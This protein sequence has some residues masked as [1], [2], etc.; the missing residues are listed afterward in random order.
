MSQSPTENP[1]VRAMIYAVVSAAV[2]V[3]GVIGLSGADEIDANKVADSVVSLVAIGSLL[4]ARA[5]VKR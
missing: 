4:L 1:K 2:L 3:A 5:N